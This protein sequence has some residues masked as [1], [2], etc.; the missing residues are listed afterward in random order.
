MVW[1]H[2]RIEWVVELHSSVDGRGSDD[3]VGKNGTSTK[4][5]RREG[6]QSHEAKQDGV[7]V[8]WSV[9]GRGGKTQEIQQSTNK[10]PAA[11]TRLQ[12][13]PD[14]RITQQLAVGQDNSRS[15]ET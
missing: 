15:R 4:H 6:H 9:G 12:S 1:R 13:Q 2:T 14:G 10:E 7:R 3:G 8:H 5:Q 11:T